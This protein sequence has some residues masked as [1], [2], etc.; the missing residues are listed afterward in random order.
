MYHVPAELQVVSDG[1]VRIVRLNRGDALNAV[2]PAMLEGLALLFPQVSADTDAR[3]LVLTGDG[4]AF[5]AGGDLEYLER[6]IS[7]TDLRRRS[8][9]TARQLVLGMVQCRV[10][11]V[12][13][14]NGPA[15]G[16]GCSLASMS[17]VVYIARSAYFADPH[18]VVGLTAA[19]GG[20]LCW[21]FHT[22]LLLAKEFAFTGERISA[23]R[24]A[25]IG[26]AN[27]VCD[28]ADVVSA[29]IAC[30]Q[31]IS[32]L[33]PQAVESTKRALNMP[34]EQAIL[35]SIDFALASEHL[36]F[37]NVEV[38]ASMERMR[39]RPAP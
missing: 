25:A 21:P 15:V 10:P 8:G 13:A 33:A 37:D 23:E 12:A 1:A 30:A 7:D 34:L 32:T 20:A 31:R 36:A 38:R 22:S 28:D 14:V 6:Q 19:D 11:I 27:H 5:S 2:N 35:A 18:V 24:A 39:G 3:A 17:D 16:L 4:R 9:A 26:L 29:A